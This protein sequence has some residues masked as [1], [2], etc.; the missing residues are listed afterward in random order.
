MKIIQLFE[1]QNKKGL[2]L[3]YIV[4]MNNLIPMNK[5]TGA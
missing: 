2:G 1:T 3:V 4:L 5:S